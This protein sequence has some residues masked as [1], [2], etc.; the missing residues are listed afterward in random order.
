MKYRS[1][2]PEDRTI[3]GGF[4]SDLLD[5]FHSSFKDNGG[6]DVSLRVETVNKQSIDSAIVDA[7]YS[8]DQTNKELVKEIKLLNARIEE[9]FDTSITEED[10]IK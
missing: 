2:P 7:I 5:L 3:V 9:A 8:L 6:K 4:W 1:T 10:L